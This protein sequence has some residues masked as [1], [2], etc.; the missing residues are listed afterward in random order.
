MRQRL[1]PYWRDH[2]KTIVGLAL[3]LTICLAARGPCC[4]A[5]LTAITSTRQSTISRGPV[6]AQSSCRRPMRARIWRSA[7]AP[8][9]PIMCRAQALMSCPA[10]GTCRRRSFRRDGQT[11]KGPG[12]MPGPFSCGPGLIPAGSSGVGRAPIYPWG[13]PAA[14]PSTPPHDRIRASHLTTTSRARP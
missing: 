5:S 12:A 6:W 2:S 3:G 14:C 4:S 7:P 10:M 9:R 8:A 13:W 1:G 11:K